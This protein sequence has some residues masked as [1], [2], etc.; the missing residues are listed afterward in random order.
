MVRRILL[1]SVI[2]DVKVYAD[3]HVVFGK[4]IKGYEVVKQVAEFPVDEKDRPL[5]PVVIS[6]C[7]ELELRR[8]PGALSQTLP[9]TYLNAI[10]T[11]AKRAQP[12]PNSEERETADRRRSLQARARSPSV[13]SDMERPRRKKSKRKRAPE[14]GQDE[15]E[16]QT[17]KLSVKETEE[18]YD[19]RL[20]REENERIEADKK[21]ELASIKRKYD[22]D[23]QNSNG[24]RFKG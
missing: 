19:A 3:K 24:I 6:N 11:L 14:Y 16:K 18:E 17:S 10:I 12:E 2:I 20:E 7:G 9:E 23:N 8:P 13:S 15:N 21:K 4:V 5:S 22:G 1:Q